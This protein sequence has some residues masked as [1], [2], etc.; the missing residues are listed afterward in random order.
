MGLETCSVTLREEHRLRVIG[1]KV[2]V[3]KTVEVTTRWRNSLVEVLH[4]L[5]ASPDT[6]P[7][8]RSRSTWWLEHG[9]SGAEQSCIDVFWGNAEERHKL[10]TLAY[11]GAQYYSGY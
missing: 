2:F 3:P 5:C 7:V 10:K 4:D 1:R 8:L 6:I 11:T 9:T